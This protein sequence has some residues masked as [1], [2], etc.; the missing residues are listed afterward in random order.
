MARHILTELGEVF[1]VKAWDQGRL[2]YLGSHSPQLEQ[3]KEEGRRLENPLW[4]HKAHSS[5][6]VTAWPSQGG[7]GLAHPL[8]GG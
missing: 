1:S 6:L 3:T 8:C 7:K 2:H 5:L 4:T